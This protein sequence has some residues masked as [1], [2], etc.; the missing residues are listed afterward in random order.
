MHNIYFYS[1]NT[2]QGPASSGTAEA[3]AASAKGTPSVP[4]AKATAPSLD[5]AKVTPS[6]HDTGP[7]ASKVIPA[8]A[9]F[10]STGRDEVT[11]AGYGEDTAT[12]GTPSL[13][14]CACNYA[15]DFGIVY[16]L[17]STPPP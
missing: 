14:S 10:T 13:H 9:E 12:E 16:S 4:D 3:T 5:T 8:C 11:A 6:G 2:P 17:Q 15:F 7:G 1:D